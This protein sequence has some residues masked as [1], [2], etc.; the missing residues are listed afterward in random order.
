MGSSVRWYLWGFS[1]PP[2]AAAPPPPPPTPPA[3][4]RNSAFSRD[5]MGLCIELPRP[6]R[7]LPKGLDCCCCC[8]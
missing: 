5:R 7:M 1:P 2:A 4:S 3:A 8:W 6:L